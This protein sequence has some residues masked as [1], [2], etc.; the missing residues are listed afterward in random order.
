MGKTGYL[1]RA[2][3]NLFVVKNTAQKIFVRRE[4]AAPQKTV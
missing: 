2:V 3:D 1:G 4:P